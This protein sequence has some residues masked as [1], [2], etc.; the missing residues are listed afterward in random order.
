MRVFRIQNK[1]RFIADIEF[2]GYAA[3]GTL[4]GQASLF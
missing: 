2:G 1:N 3:F 4:C